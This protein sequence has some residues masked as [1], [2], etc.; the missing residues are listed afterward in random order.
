[1]KSHEDFVKYGFC[2]KYILHGLSTDEEK[3]FEEHLL[4]CR[5][6]REEI[7]HLIKSV[8]FIKDTALNTDVYIKPV[9]NNQNERIILYRTIGIAAAIIVLVAVSWFVY[10][11]FRPGKIDNM[12]V[13]NDTTKNNL[14]SNDSGIR[15]NSITREV[16][17]NKVSDNFVTLARYETLVNS[18]FRSDAVEVKC[19]LINQKFKAGT[20]VEFRWNEDGLKI[21]QLVIF[22]NKGK[23]LAEQEIQTVFILKKELQPGLYYWQLETETEAIYTGKFTVVE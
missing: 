7:Q 13:S 23:V 12:L 14:K 21:L 6:C 22:D 10:N 2:E 3:I 20:P 17:A 18:C 15:T 8:E 1:M 9:S 11:H 19:P 16:T 4:Y 5:I